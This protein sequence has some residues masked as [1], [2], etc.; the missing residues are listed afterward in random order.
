MLD[1]ERSLARYQTAISMVKGEACGVALPAV[2]TA[3]SEGPVEE[4]GTFVM[5]PVIP[6]AEVA[7]AILP[8]R[9]RTHHATLDAGLN[10][11]QKLAEVG[12]LQSMWPSQTTPASD[13]C[14]VPRE[15]VAGPQLQIIAAQPPIPS[16]KTFKRS[17][18]ASTV[19]QAFEK[20]KVEIL[21]LKDSGYTHAEICERIA[22]QPRPPNAAWGHLMWSQALRDPTFKN[23]VK[24][25][26]SR[27]K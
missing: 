26:I 10:E 27:L 6:D 3:T 11:A 14:G 13:V 4:S 8:F 5:N 1:F 7:E 18:K 17:G 16:G 15:E 22:K 24:S 9:P 19:K 2:V 25:W 20:V 12:N 23:A 21:D